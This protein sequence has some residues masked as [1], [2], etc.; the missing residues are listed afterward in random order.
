MYI[1]SLI[2]TNLSHFT[3][4][5]DTKIEALSKGTYPCSHYQYIAKSRFGCRLNLLGWVC[6]PPICFPDKLFQNLW[7]IFAWQ[8]STSPPPFLI[9]HPAPQ[10]FL[11]SISGIC[12]FFSTS[13]IHCPKA[14]ANQLPSLMDPSTSANNS[15]KH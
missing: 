3:H 12:F 14:T 13:V 5:S 11:H 1:L 2:N 6:T 8:M 15:S 9:N 4:F 7:D 10:F